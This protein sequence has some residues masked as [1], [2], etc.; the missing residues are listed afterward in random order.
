MSFQGIDYELDNFPGKYIK[1]NRAFL[2]AKVDNMAIGCV[3]LRKIDNDTCEM[4]RLYVSNE[5]KGKGIG[6]ALVEKIIMKAK[7]MNYI[8]IRL[9]TLPKMKTAQELYKN[10]GFYEIEQYTENPIIGTKFME[11][12]LK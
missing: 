12:L 7:N 1:P 3:G 5:Y 11:K 10:F 4:K 2:V 6:K 9:D 8:K